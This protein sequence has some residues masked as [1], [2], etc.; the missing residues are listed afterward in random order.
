M[1][2]PN[3]HEGKTLHEIKTTIE[4]LFVEYIRLQI[5]Y[6]QMVKPELEEL[7]FLEARV[8]TDDGGLYFWSL[9]HVDGPKIK[10][11]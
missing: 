1:N 2:T 11:K 7:T 8:D 9:I 10:L 3:E 6:T 5:L 4:Q